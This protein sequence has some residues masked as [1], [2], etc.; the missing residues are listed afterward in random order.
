MGDLITPPNTVYKFWRVSPFE[1][2][3]FFVGVL[4]T[5][6]SSIENGIYVA[7]GVSGGLLI[8]RI[9]KAHGHFMGKVKVHSV[10]GDSLLSLVKEGAVVSSTGSSATELPSGDLKT[11]ASSS[12]TE[13][14]ATNY[15]TT[16]LPLAGIKNY[17]ALDLN[18]QGY[19]GTRNVF[20]PIDHRD[21]SNPMVELANPY[22]GVFIYRFSEGF[23]YANAA[24]YT[25]RLVAHIFANTR[26]GN[27]H[28]LATK[29]GD[30][31]WNEAGP[32]D[33]VRQAEIESVRPTLKA[34]ILDF[35]SVN[36]VDITSV[37]NLLD[38]RN[39]LD[40]YAAPGYVEWHFAA[41]GNRWTKRAL[42]SAGFG[43]PVDAVRRR[44]GWKPV[45]SVAEIGSSSQE[46]S[47][48]DIL[49]EIEKAKGLDPE[50][51]RGV[52]S[53]TSPKSSTEK[54]RKVRVVP[55]GGIALPFFHVDIEGA[56]ESAVTS[57]RED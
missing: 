54:R 8:F 7:V 15:R 46:I 1:C 38:V 26:R 34:V 42:S 35:S 37:Q 57:V 33:P 6:F 22:P 3:I 40:R 53:S 41:I 10:I 16:T 43:Y 9:A 18:D 36:N 24:H 32:K 56:V 19:D 2:V 28:S 11:A 23:V 49:R 5:V 52:T 30:R 25:E 20:L 44:A 39:Q 55:V 48:D 27:P 29:N 4:V 31:A 45:F 51:G 17:G 14:P 21:G 13:L 50:A 47:E 12:V